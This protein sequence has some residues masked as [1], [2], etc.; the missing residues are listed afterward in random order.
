M[1]V[2]KS[3]HY[4]KRTSNVGKRGRQHLQHCNMAAV[5]FSFTKLHTYSQSWHNR[6]DEFYDLERVF[7]GK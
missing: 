2:Q 7:N 1:M 6:F 5:S 3:W 4:K